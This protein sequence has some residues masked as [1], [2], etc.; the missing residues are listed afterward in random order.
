MTILTDR[1]RHLA[2]MNCQRKRFIGYEVGGRGLQPLQTPQYFAVGTAVHNIIED[3]WARSEGVSFTPMEE[4]AQQIVLDGED[5]HQVVVEQQALIKAIGLAYERVRLP[6]LQQEFKVVDIEPEILI[7]VGEGVALM[8]RPDLILQRHHDGAFIVNELKTT[9]GFSWGWTMGWQENLQILLENL[10]LKQWLLSHGHDVDRARGVMVEGISKGKR[11]KDALGSRRYESPL[12]YEKP[13]SKYRELV[14]DV[15][16]HVASLDEAT[17][18]AQFSPL[19]PI[20]TDPAFEGR[21]IRQ[22]CANEKNVRERRTHVTQPLQK[23]LCWEWE[24][25]WEDADRDF[26]QNPDECSRFG[27]DSK[28]EFYSICWGQAGRN[29]LEFGYQWRKPNHQ[30]EKEILK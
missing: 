12:I 5:L 28:C 26:P 27:G 7:D 6:K 25:V 9:S 2:G 29:P 30:L 15:E 14:Y 23:G 10:A 8:T 19:Q 16:S 20:M 18:E 4:E 11:T 3:A 17:V 21:V 22:I 1:S 24:N 13:T